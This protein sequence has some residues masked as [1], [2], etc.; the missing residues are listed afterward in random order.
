MRSARILLTTAAASAVLV[1]G[2]PGAHA[3]GDDWDSS[4]SSWSKEHNNPKYDP[5]TYKDK[6]SEGRESGGGKHEGGGWSGSHEKPSGGMHTGGGGLASPAVTTGGLA[7]LGV[8]AAGLYAAR[9]K[10]T[11]GSMA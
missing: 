3:A 8:A 4:G 7:M 9:R 5:E 10:R 11:V 2:A 1:L 6:D